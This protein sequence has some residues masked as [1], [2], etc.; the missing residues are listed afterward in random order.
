LF[1][2][3]PGSDRWPS[4]ARFSHE[5][6]QVKTLFARA[7]ATSEI[8]SVTPEDLARMQLV[9]KNP[10]EPRY[11]LFQHGESQWWLWPFF[12]PGAAEAIKGAAV[13]LGTNVVAAHT[14][15]VRDQEHQTVASAWV[16]WFEE[17]WSR[18]YKAGEVQERRKAALKGFLARKGRTSDAEQREL[19]DEILTVVEEWSIG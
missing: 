14:T 3:F 6:D 8:L 7:L 4:P 5:R 12:E 1:H 10:R 18:F 2:C 11:A 17:N 16:N 15:L 19:W 13:K 9:A